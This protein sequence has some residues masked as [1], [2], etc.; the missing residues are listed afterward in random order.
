M[1]PDLNQIKSLF[2]EAVEKHAPDGWPAFLVACC[3][4]SRRVV[5]VWDSHAG[6]LLRNFRGHRGL[7]SS[8]AFCPDGRRLASGSRDSTVKVWDL[9]PVSAVPGRYTSR[10]AE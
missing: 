5:K 7:V 9:T 10:G 4:W 6:K 3:F 8:L 1:N 2:L